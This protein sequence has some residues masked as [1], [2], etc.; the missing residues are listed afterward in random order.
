[1]VS[2][3]V[4][5]NNFR[6]SHVPILVSDTPAKGDSIFP[7]FEDAKAWVAGVLTRDIEQWESCRNTSYTWE[8]HRD[9]GYEYEDDI[10]AAKEIG[11]AKRM[12]KVVKKMKDPSQ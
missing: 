11:R 10:Q 7:S 1:M 9:N 12:L 6:Y 2:Q 3:T 4:V 5:P 8:S